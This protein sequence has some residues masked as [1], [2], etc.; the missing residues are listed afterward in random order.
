MRRWPWVVLVVCVA[1][2]FGVPRWAAV[3]TA[4]QYPVSAADLA[5]GRAALATLDVAA[6]GPLEGY[7]RTQFGQAWA[8]VDSNGCDTRNDV[9]ARD[10]TDTTTDDGCHVLSGTLDDPYTGQHVAFVRGPRSA[11]VQVDHVVALADAWRKGADRWDPARRLAFAN[12]PANLRAVSGKANQDKGAS[13]A[14]AWLP[15]PGYRCVYVL[16]Q[17][18]V[19]AAYG[20]SVTPAEKA[21]MSR[22]LDGCRTVAADETRRLSDE[23]RP[24]DQVGL[25]AVPLRTRRQAPAGAVICWAGSPWETSIRRGLASSAT[26]MV[27]VRTPSA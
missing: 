20:L 10:L 1:V 25:G 21:A 15:Q 23:R 6:A 17:V 5:D 12:D 7:D 14:A 24:P 26:G 9:L 22:A 8:D 19:K 2:G 27:R 11:D 16:L 3:R 13:D 18:R 4:A